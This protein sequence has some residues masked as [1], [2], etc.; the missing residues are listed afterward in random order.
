[1]EEYF[2]AGLRGLVLGVARGLRGFGKHHK[3]DKE[4]FDAIFFLKSLGI[5]VVIGVCVEF[6]KP[7]LPVDD[8]FILDI[9][10]DWVAP[11]VG[12]DLVEDILE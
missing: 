9:V 10:T 8:N 2:V 4:S 3:I 11:W 1:M 6:L 5:S 12:T 7:Y